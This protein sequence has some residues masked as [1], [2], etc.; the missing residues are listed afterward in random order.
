MKINP[1]YKSIIF[2]IVIF[3]TGISSAQKSGIKQDILNAINTASIAMEDGLLYEDGHAKGDYNLLT[4]EWELYEPAWHTGQIIYALTRAYDITKNNKYLEVAKKAG[5]WW[6]NLEIKDHPVLKGMVKTIHGAG[7]NF[8]VF[9]TMSDGSAGLF[10]LYDITGESLYADIPTQAGKWMYK[11]MWEPESRMFYDA[12]DPVTGKV[13][14]EWSPF[15]EDKK[16]QVLNDVA[17]PNNEGSLFK[18]MYEYTKDEQYKDLF[19]QLCESLLEKQGTEGIWMDFT[20]NNKDEGYFHPRF[21]I[22][23][24]ESLLEGYDLTGDKRYLEAALK[25]GRFYTKFQ[26]KTGAFFYRNYLDGSADKFSISGST[27]AF[28][29]I[30]WLRLL[31]Y[32]VGNEFEENIIKSVQWIL[33][34]QFPPHHPDKNLAGQFLELKTK[35]KKAEVRIYNR[36]VGTP[37]CV[38]FLC[39]YY[40]HISK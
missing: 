14:K 1:V 35:Q 6:V 32:G 13:M 3:F 21:N 18:D 28:S 22:W 17:R 27:T 16:E 38:R 12:V 19:I 30:L 25:V 29:G 8:I 4:G 34:N 24:A 2:C 26:Q 37:F 11:H 10:R 40:E 15:W 7:I 20:P 33:Q 31:N 9:A 23:Y 36:D 39:D 5:D